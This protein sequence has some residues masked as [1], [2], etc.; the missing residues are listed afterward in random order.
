[1]ASNSKRSLWLSNVVSV[2][3]NANL[4]CLSSQDVDST[5]TKQRHLVSSTDRA[6]SLILSNV[7]NFTQIHSLKS[8]NAVKN[9]LKKVKK[10]KK[11]L[12]QSHFIASFRPALLIGRVKILLTSATNSPQA[13]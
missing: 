2:D 9:W 1:M 6:E 8:T 11:R 12:D 13:K 5:A 4:E 7:R 3:L 10:H